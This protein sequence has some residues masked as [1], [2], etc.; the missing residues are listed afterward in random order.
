MADK[1][2]TPNENATWIF[3]SHSNEDY[4]KVTVLRDMLEELKKRPI[5]LYLKCM[6]DARYRKQLW[7]LLQREIDAR[8]QF[9]LC[10]SEN[11]RNSVWVQ[12][13]VRYIK[14][15]GRKYQTI[16]IDAFPELIRNNVYDFVNRDRVFISY[17]R[18]DFQVAKALS[19][20][21]Q[22]R[23]YSVFFDLNT[24]RGGDF[25]AQI[26]HEIGESKRRGYQICLLSRAYCQSTYCMAELNRILSTTNGDWLLL[27]QLDNIPSEEYPESINGRPV[28]DI[29]KEYCGAW[30]DHIVSLFVRMEK[31]HNK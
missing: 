16:H 8:E 17:S 11:A 15:K 2:S 25:S 9:I 14:S 30:V 3:L 5:M 12:E 19:V 10:D 23:G 20:A 27:I 13:E 24:I 31:N 22:E 7:D 6:E 18:H 21:L 28:F 4:D 26:N 29:S 1:N